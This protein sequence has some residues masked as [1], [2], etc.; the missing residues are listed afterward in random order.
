MYSNTTFC[1]AIENN[2]FRWLSVIRRENA[3]DHCTTSL[4][5]VISCLATLPYGRSISLRS[6]G[7]SCNTLRSLS[8]TSR[9]PP[10]QKKK[11]LKSGCGGYL[12]STGLTLIILGGDCVTCHERVCITHVAFLAKP[13]HV[14]A[15]HCHFQR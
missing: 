6:L 11:K 12:L 13:L 14:F 5:R 9:L 2:Y 3:L 4:H 1:L 10:P 8:V 15:D 7:M